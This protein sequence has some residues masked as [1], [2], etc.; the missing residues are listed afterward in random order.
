MDAEQVNSI[1]KRHGIPQRY[2]T[3]FRKLIL[4]CR[5]DSDRLNA[6]L[7]R[8]PVFAACLEEMLDLLSEPY[9]HLFEP[10]DFEPLEC[11]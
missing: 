2:W 4:D 1:C 8:D 10:S 3:E 7:D 11:R 5:I 9:R 6:L